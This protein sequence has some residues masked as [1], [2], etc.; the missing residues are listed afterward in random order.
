MTYVTNMQEL[1]NGKK[2]RKRWD[3]NLGP[4]RYKSTTIPCAS[5]SAKLESYSEKLGKKSGPRE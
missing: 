4:L 3:L 5:S 2:S 1:R